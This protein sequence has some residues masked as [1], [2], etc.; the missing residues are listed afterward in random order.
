MCLAIPARI[1]QLLDNDEALVEAGGIEK[2][3]SLALI[4][5]AAIGDYVVVHTGFALNK[6]DT[7]EAE[8]TLKL[9]ADM[10]NIDQQS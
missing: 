5:E 1:C 10:T 2:V 8:K 9:F 3:I 4:N 7:F 6:L